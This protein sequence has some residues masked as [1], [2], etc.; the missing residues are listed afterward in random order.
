MLFNEV[1]V[2]MK[3]SVSSY[4]FSRIYDKKSFDIIKIL[5]K[6]KE[7]G[8]TGLEIAGFPQTDEKPLELCAKV[9]KRAAGLGMEITNYA[10]GADFIYGSGGNLNAEIERVKKEVDFAAAFGAKRMRHDVAYGFSPE[11]PPP[12]GFDD[13]V[14]RLAEGCRAVTEYA[15]GKG[16]VTSVE[17]HGYFCQESG[18]VEKLI[19]KVGHKN[20]GVCLDIGNFVCADENPAYAAGALAPYIKHVHLKDFFIKDGMYP[21]PGEG[22]FKSRGG[23]HLRGAIL[24]HGNIPVDQIVKIIHNSGYRGYYSLEFEGMEDVFTGVSLGSKYM[25]KLL[26]NLIN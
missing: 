26:N 17:N 25:F 5:E 2:F 12:K 19:N 6:T 16:V 13:I 14:D 15:E 10:V 24:G 21:D 3:T 9:K 23:T 18:R 1:K 20:F 7:Y 22:W 11:T 8:F 4:S